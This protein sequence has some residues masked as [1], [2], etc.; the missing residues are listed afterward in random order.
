MKTML[1]INDTLLQEAKSFA[2]QQRTTLTKLIEEG[3]RMRLQPKQADKR[4]N[5]AINL[6]T[7]PSKEGR[8]MRA[9]IDPLSNKSLYDAADGLSS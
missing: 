2:A 1:N 9:G 4:S 6:P 5:I 7:L 8:G 3:L